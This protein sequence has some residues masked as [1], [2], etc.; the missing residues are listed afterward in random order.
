[1]VI[2]ELFFQLIDHL[3][4]LFDTAATFFVGTLSA[5][6]ATL[7][8]RAIWTYWRKPHLDFKDETFSNW[9]NSESQPVSQ[10]IV[11]VEN[12]GL[13][14]AHNCRPRI[15]LR[16][17]YDSKT[18][19]METTSHWDESGKPSAITINPDESVSFVVSRQF[20]EANSRMIFPVEGGWST[21]TGVIQEYIGSEVKDGVS[22]LGGLPSDAL[23][24]GEWRVREVSVSSN[25]AEKISGRFCI[26][27]DSE[28]GGGM[29]S[30]KTKVCKKSEGKASI[31]RRAKSLFLGS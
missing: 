3:S 26:T 16:G 10:N 13:T 4:S 24:D 22:V 11:S 30:R 5:L 23:D 12:T 18:Y 25:D 19:V 20:N 2:S 9:I 1:M 7:I 29:N 8:A 17:E 15:T 14:A 6:L 28:A 21:D 31:C 27:L